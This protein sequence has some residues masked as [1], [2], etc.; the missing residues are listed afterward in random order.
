LTAQS[1]LENDRTQLPPLHQQLSVARHALAVLVGQAPS[2][3][4]TP[5][6]DFD[7][8]KMPETIPVTLPS[9][10]VRQRPDILSAEALLHADSAAIGIATAN[11]YPSLT[12]SFSDT[13]Q[14]AMFNT[15]FN[16]ASKLLSTSFNGNWNVYEGGTLESQK[17]GA[18]DAYDAQ[19]ATYR[20]TV[21]TAFGQVAD[22]L[23][24]IDNDAESLRLAQNALNI[25]STSLRL[26]RA[27][28]S[29]GKSNVLQLITAEN[30][31]AQASMNFVRMQGQR[32]QDCVV[33][34]TA[35]GGGWQSKEGIALPANK[36]A[37]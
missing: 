4:Q 14:S 24:A 19:L 21:L 2:Q 37:S 29:A 32:L 5:D 22:A 18:I 1:Q 3:W 36:P 13:Y 27:S 10:L 35:L 23:R 31:Y 6:F 20:Q 28:Y 33:L 15:L 8:F 17:R 16:S 34:F 25:S 11:I 30:S 12:L 7:S 26:Q 9:E